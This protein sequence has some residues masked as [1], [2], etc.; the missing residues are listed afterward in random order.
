M[1]NRLNITLPED[2]LARADAFAKR[3]RYTRSGLIAAALD[4]FLSGETSGAEV[5]REPVA[6]Y[7]PEAV[8]LNPAVRPLVP[9]IIDACRRHD[10]VYAALVG[11]STQPDPAVTPRDLDILV[12]FAPCDEGYAARYFDLRAEL[13]SLTGKEIDLI[14]FDALRNQRL[15]AEFERTKVVLYEVA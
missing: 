7:A 10:V 13:A 5:A 15:R 8:G 2:V 6:V 11:S 3:E 12:R 14:E 1:Y 9:A 4:A